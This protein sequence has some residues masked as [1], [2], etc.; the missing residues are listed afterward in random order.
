VSKEFET[1][2]CAAFVADLAARGYEAHICSFVRRTEGLRG[3][4]WLV[5]GV[6]SLKG[7][8]MPRLSIGVPAIGLDVA[9]LSRD[10]HQ[11]VDPD[12]GA[13]WY[14]WGEGSTASV[15]KA[16]ADLLTEGLPWLEKHL[17]V[18]GLVQALEQER[19]RPRARAKKAWWRLGA[20]SATDLAPPVRLNVLQFLSYA[21]ELQG[22]H[23]PALES[24]ERYIAGHSRLE[25]GSSLEQSLTE[26]LNVLK[27]RAKS[28][29]LEG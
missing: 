8:F 18:D 10:L 17:A 15:A 27:A 4:V 7:Y 28:S 3:T 24:W 14:A 19:D 26:R 16:R 9:V 29:R 11:L 6:S 1:S 13:R 21:Y 23:A 25:K 2:V 12:T 20:P 5:E 22:R